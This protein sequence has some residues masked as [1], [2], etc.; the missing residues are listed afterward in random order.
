MRHGRLRWALWGVLCFILWP[1][2]VTAQGDW[3]IRQ[4]QEHL[5]AAEFDPGPIDGIFG[6]RLKAALRQYQ[7]VHGLQVT[8]MLDEATRKSLDVRTNQMTRK[9]S[10]TVVEK[11]LGSASDK[12][13]KAGL[14]PLKAPFHRPFQY[15][16]MSIAKAAKATGGTPNTVGNIIIDSDRAHMLLEAEGNFSSYVDVELKQTA[17]C[18]LTRAFDSEPVLGALSINPS[19]LDFARKQT[20][21]HTYYDHK[22]KL[23]VS[24]SCQ[25][26][27]GPLSAG[28]SSKYYGM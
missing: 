20:H 4:V 21:F 26:N 14:S 6:P 28:F 2:I 27:G 12:A 17:P 7:A 5:E 19:E 24:V 22:R 13:I 1:A 11:T 15:I 16:G 23:K 8:G 25:Y 10:G 3:Q 18:S 9:P